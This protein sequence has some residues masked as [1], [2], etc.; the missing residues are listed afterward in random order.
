MTV[1]S[2]FRCLMSL[3]VKYSYDI[4][5]NCTIS[6]DFNMYTWPEVFIKA[7]PS[8]FSDLQ[9]HRFHANKKFSLTIA[10]P[11][12]LNRKKSYVIV[13]LRHLFSV[14]VSYVWA[15]YVFSSVP[16]PLDSGHSLSAPVKK[17]NLCFD[18][19]CTVITHVFMVS[20]IKYDSRLPPHLSVCRPSGSWMVLQSLEQQLSAYRL[21]TPQSYARTRHINE[22]DFKSYLFIFLS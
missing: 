11:F 20:V 13:S 21:H 9:S 2:D 3:I 4:Q 14:H 5:N 12:N 19:K 16:P 18:A 22:N 7:Y 15:A 8:L 6:K 1:K 17:L 10:F